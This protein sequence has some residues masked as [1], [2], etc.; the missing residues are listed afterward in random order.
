MGVQAR[1]G[2]LAGRL[3]E[4]HRDRADMTADNEGFLDFLRVF[5]KVY[6]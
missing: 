5:T 2:E 1:I 6:N 3:V 4:M